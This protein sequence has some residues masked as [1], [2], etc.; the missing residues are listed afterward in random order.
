[1]RTDKK[2]SR[3]MEKNKTNE[4]KNYK[5]MCEILHEKE[6]RGKSE[7][8]KQFDVWK[9]YFEFHNN[10]QK[11]IIDKVLDENV[12]VENEKQQK[13]KTEL[14]KI[15]ERS[16]YRKI[17]FPILIYLLKNAPENK[18]EISPINLA[19]RCGFL[20]IKIKEKRKYN[21]YIAYR[22]CMKNKFKNMEKSD[23]EEIV[24]RAEQKKYL[25]KK[26]SENTF[27]QYQ[28][29]IQ[30][31]I[32]SVLENLLDRLQETNI[33]EYE[34]SFF[35]FDPDNKIFKELSPGEKEE[36]NNICETARVILLPEYLNTVSKNKTVTKI[37]LKDFVYH[38]ELKN[39]YYEIIKEQM[40]DK[41]WFDI[42]IRHFKIKLKNSDENLFKE[43]N[44]LESEKDFN[45]A[46]INFNYYY[47]TELKK[48]A[49]KKIMK[50]KKTYEKN[51]SDNI[52]DKDSLTRLY[53][54]DTVEYYNKIEI[55]DLLVSTA[56]VIDPIDLYTKSET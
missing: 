31:N 56:Y 7:K 17:L 39:R 55:I 23:D 46:L 19:I 8:G 20:S 26:M 21:D 11:F 3:Y 30:K 10:G 13:E 35:G 40:Q 45:T 25:Q 2:I 49:D 9:M 36:Y 41:F 44:S 52:I 1:M 50:I 15:F 12:I 27:F 37:E 47:A 34:I 6:K 4:V 32:F 16:K 42:V 51:M 38:K 22:N 53:R 43:F 33:I 5:K 54:F 18:L 24:K 48:L 14:L 28:R 29:D